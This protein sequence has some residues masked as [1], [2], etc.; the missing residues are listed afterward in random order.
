[1]NGGI[2]QCGMAY[3]LVLVS[4]QCQLSVTGTS[5][6]GQPIVRHSGSNSS[7]ALGSTTAPDRMWAPISEPFSRTHTERSGLSCFTRIDAAR[8]AG[9]PPTI[10][11]S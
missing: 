8:P 2:G 7:S 9:P 10:T 6:M 3:F 11:T 5:A 4:T 1:M